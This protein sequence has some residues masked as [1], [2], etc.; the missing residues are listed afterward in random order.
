MVS[1]KK[2]NIPQLFD[3]LFKTLSGS[4]FINR[5]GLGG[6]KPIFIQPYEIAQQ[7]A[8]DEQIQSLVKRLN[9]ANVPVLAID[10]YNL[11][12]EVLIA[13]GTLQK[14]LENE[15]NL[16]KREFKRNLQGSLSVKDNIMPYIQEKMKETE[17]RMVFIYGIDKV[18]QQLS[19]VPVLVN[20]QSLLN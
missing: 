5:E 11:C 18:Y 20:I 19:M 16:P 4:R 8:V 7:V 9:A 13:K 14:V 17:H 3:K 10:L 12:L 6:N 15:Q 2:E 1:T